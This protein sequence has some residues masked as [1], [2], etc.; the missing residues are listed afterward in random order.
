MVKPFLDSWA[1]IKEKVTTVNALLLFL[2]F[3]Y[4]PEM[5]DMH[6]EEFTVYL[7]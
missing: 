1:S 3:R 2:E 6:M 5:S 7:G 4:Y